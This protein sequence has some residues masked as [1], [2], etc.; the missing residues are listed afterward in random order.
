MSARWQKWKT[1]IFFQFP[2]ETLNKQLYP[3]PSVPH[4]NSE[5]GG[6]RH[7]TA[8]RA[9]ALCVWPTWVRSLPSCMIPPPCFT[10]TDPWEQSLEHQWVWPSNLHYFPSKKRFIMSRPLSHALKMQVVEFSQHFSSDV[11][12]TNV[13]FLDETV[14]IVSEWLNSREHRQA[15]LLALIDAPQGQD[16]LLSWQLTQLAFIQHWV[17]MVATSSALE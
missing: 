8:S 9:L 1:S 3:C 13:F 15:V 6:H 14:T 5:V 11:P 10:G 17:L 12:L 16:P 2:H 7:N 4:K